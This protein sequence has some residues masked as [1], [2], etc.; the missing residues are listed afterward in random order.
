VLCNLKWCC[1][2]LA[3]LS[4]SKFEFYKLGK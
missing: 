2:N 1:R 3:F 4:V